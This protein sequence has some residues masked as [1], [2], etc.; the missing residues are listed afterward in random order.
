MEIL[1][2]IKGGSVRILIADDHPIFRHGVRKILEAE[3]DFTVVGEA[4]DAKQ[5]LELATKLKPRVLL[6][7]LAMP[8]A[9]G[10]EALRE[11]ARTSSPALTI[12]LTAAIETPQIVEAI[13]LGARGIILKDASSAVLI[14][15]IRAVLKGQ[16]WIG[17]EKVSDVVQVLHRY[18]PPHSASR[19]RQNFGLTPREL[20]VV[21]A[22]VA[23]YTNSEIAHK[24]KLSEQT[25]KHHIT[26]IFD[27]L[28]VSNRMELALFAVTHQLEGGV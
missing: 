26:N 13:Q 25:I 5:T 15:C 9:S 7:D 28:G 4:E 21:A 8:G 20:E 11:L 24:F 23:G 22:V 10:L 18:L 3:P 12:V 2:D 16:H 1:D 27:K 14:E 19:A 6:V 17:K